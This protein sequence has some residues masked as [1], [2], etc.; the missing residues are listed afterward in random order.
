LSVVIPDKDIIIMA[1]SSQL[2]QI[3]LNLATNARDAMPDGGK[4]FISVSEMKIN[5]A[6]IREHGYGEPGV[7]AVITVQDTGT[8]IDEKTRE[9]LFEPFFTTKDVGKGTGLGLAIVY[10]IVKQHNGFISV[11]SEPGRGSTFKVLLPAI[12]TRAGI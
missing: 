3:L 2:D 8:G 12:K 7:Y 5:D 10:G 9:K 4:L 6:Y 11:F 1:D